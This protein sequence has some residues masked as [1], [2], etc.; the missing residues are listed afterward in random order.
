[1]NL[2]LDTHIALWALNDNPRLP[3]AARA[4][5]MDKENSVTV[6]VATLWEISIKHPLDR[7]GSAMPISGSDALQLFERAQFRLLLVT[8]EHAVAVETLP[9]IHQ[10]PFDRLLVAQAITEPMR[11]VT[12]DRLLARYS[13][14][15]MVV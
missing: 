7:K 5:V 15:V 8:A 4:L 13:D 1:M 6:S 3:K 9:P 2:L 14:T 12:S 10:D 11:L